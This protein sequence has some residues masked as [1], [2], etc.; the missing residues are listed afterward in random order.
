MSPVYGV[1]CCPFLRWMT[2]GGTGKSKTWC[3][4]LEPLS[5]V[6]EVAAVP[7]LLPQ[8]CPP[9]GVFP[10]FPFPAEIRS[11]LLIGL[12]GTRGAL[13]NLQC[14]LLLSEGSWC[15]PLQRDHPP[16][17]A[18]HEQ[19]EVAWR[20]AVDRGQSG[21]NP[22]EPKLRLLVFSIEEVS[23]GC[24]RQLGNGEQLS[25]GKV[26]ACSIFNPC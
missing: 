26:K 9:T 18:L 15:F 8:R 17:D 3:K 11:V 1:I 12:I 5:R 16:R 7:K 6:S 2:L 23:E 22:C 14:L 20:G 21:E 25:Y 19:D 24:W 13:M 4:I 10:E